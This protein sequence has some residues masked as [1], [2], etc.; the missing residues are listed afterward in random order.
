[1]EIV[2]AVKEDLARSAQ[3]EAQASKGSA[4]APDLGQTMNARITG[5]LERQITI[6]NSIL[7]RLEKVINKRLA[8]K[9]AVQMLDDLPGIAAG[10]ENASQQRMRQNIIEL[11]ILGGGIQAAVA[12]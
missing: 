11:E 1:M 6:A 5:M 10:M 4:A 9:I 7:A 8:A 2:N 12:Q 3:Y